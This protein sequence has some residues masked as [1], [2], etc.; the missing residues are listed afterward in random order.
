MMKELICCSLSEVG[1]FLTNAADCLLLIA[2][3]NG[4][5]LLFYQ[6]EKLHPQVLA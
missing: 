4:P 2:N 5:E 1:S 3:Y 6:Q